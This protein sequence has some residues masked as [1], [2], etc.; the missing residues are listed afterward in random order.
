LPED[1]DADFR[2]RA[3]SARVLAR[4][5]QFDEAERLAREATEIVEATDWY[6]QRGEAARALGEVMEL[7]GR[8]DEARAAYEWA[9]ECFERKGM[10]PDAVEVRDRLAARSGRR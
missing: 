1:F 4:R 2:R 5:G 9:V 6:M 8:T 10:F 7:A 3:L